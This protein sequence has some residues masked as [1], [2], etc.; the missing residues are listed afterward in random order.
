MQVV[1]RNSGIDAASY[2]SDNMNIEPFE[3]AG[4]STGSFE[5]RAPEQE[6]EY[7]LYCTDCKLQDQKFVIKIHG[8]APTAPATT[9]AVSNGM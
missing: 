8:N 7:S 3:V 5:W 6:G 1:V 4:R 9:A 2:R